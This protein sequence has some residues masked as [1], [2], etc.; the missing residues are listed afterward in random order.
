[1][2]AVSLTTSVWAQTA[3][4]TT[5]TTTTTTDATPSDDEVQ[6]LSPFQVTSEKDTGYLRTNSVTATRINMPIQNIPISVSVMA[7]DFID[8]NNIRSITD[9]FRYSSSGSGDNRF[10]MARPANSA[11]PQ[12]GF[13]LRGFGVNSILRNGVARYNA[14]NINNIDRVEV[15]K[16]PASVFFGSGYPGGVINYITKQPV[17]GK[18]PTTITHQVG[19]NNV[20]RVVLDHNAQLSRKAAMRVVASWENSSGERNFEFKKENSL[21]ANVTLVPFDSGKLT[22]TAEIETIDSKVN[23]NQNDWYFPEGWFKAYAAPSQALI[24]A[25]GLAANADPVAAYRARIFSNGAGTW[26]QDTRNATGDQTLP[27]YTRV[28]KGAYY[29]DASGNY[30]HD[31]GFNS[32][33]RGSYSNN[34]NDTG[35]VTV[36]LSPASFVDARYVLTN[37]NGRFDN[38]EGFTLPNADARTFNTQYGLNTAGYWLRR[39][40][41]QV[42][43]ILKYD[44]FGIKNRLL[45][46]GV[47]IKNRQQYNAVAGAPFN[48]F[49]SMIP[50]ASNPE[51]NLNNTLVPAAMVPSAGDVPSAQVIRDRFGK[52]KTVTQ[53]FTNWDPGAEVQ[54]DNHRVVE[55][56]RT[57]VDGYDTEDQAGYLNYQGSL[58]NDRLTL[59]AGVRREMHRDSGQYLTGNFPWFA[60]PPYAFTDQTTYPQGLYNYSASYAGDTNNFQRQA[61]TSWMGGASFQVAKDVN[62]FASYSKVFRLNSGTKGSASQLDIPL[63]YNAAKAWAQNTANSAYNASGA[64]NYR[65]QSITSYDQFHDALA[66]LGAFDVIK[67]ETGYNAEV[68]VKTTLWDNKLV[69][70][71]S[72]FHAERKDQKYDDGTAQANEPLNAAYSGGGN[73]AIFGPAGNPYSGARLLR[74]RTTATR[75]RIEGADFDVT[76]TPIR[77]FQAVVNGAWMWTAEVADSLTAK[78][79]TAAYTAYTPAQKVSANILYGSRIANVPEYRLNAFANYTFTDGPVAGLTVGGAMRYSSKTVV[80]QSVDWNPLNG[81]FQSGDFTTFD[82]SVGYQWELFG[83]KIGSRLAVYNVTDE[84]YVEGPTYVLSPARSWLLTNTLK[85]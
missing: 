16:G 29:Q 11:T 3:K 55:I 80:S 33:N 50:G 17:F 57:A 72:I 9:I 70:T 59:L 43:A 37:E 23:A 40:N 64:F 12:G 69:G 8:D 31:T 34:H 6:T 74:W 49:Y 24:N 10:T 1:M 77:N 41:H 79:G 14:Y 18:I 75:N 13:T 81:G 58:L 5:T 61:G 48:R 53:V 56:D 51:G 38:V 47:F 63:W 73:V 39:Q 27:T 42:D 66:A 78:P 36:A 65:G 30:I 45:V 62:V 44:K 2:A 68:G 84:K 21:T 82:V 52:I 32:T 54:P 85:F 67:P 83:Y 76:W 19:E 15:V 20:N 25:A 71:A 35:T 26:A 46:G 7:K 4:T 22:I 60:N 28:L